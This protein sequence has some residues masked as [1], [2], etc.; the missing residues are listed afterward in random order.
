[1][2]AQATC[3]A[4]DRLA[5]RAGLD[6]RAAQRMAQRAFERGLRH[7]EVEGSLRRYLDRLWFDHRKANNI[8]IY[9]EFVYLF[10]GTT[11]LTVFGFPKKYRRAAREAARV[12]KAAA[13]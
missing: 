3:H 4:L 6:R 12:R 11:L 7:S 5:E 2:T 1:M 8:R 10:G 13:P 9:G